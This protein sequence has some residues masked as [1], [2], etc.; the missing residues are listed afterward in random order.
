MIAASVKAVNCTLELVVSWSA[1]AA[2]EINTANE[3]ELDSVREL[4]LSSCARILKALEGGPFTDWQDVMH[5][6]KG[7][8]QATAQKLLHA[9]LTVNG[10]APEDSPKPPSTPKSP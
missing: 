9:G 4:G 7:I 2:V 3:V 1:Y 10:Q 8:N 5:S 6:V